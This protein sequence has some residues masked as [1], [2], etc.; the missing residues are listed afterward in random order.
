MIFITRW[1]K[2]SF[3]SIQLR[4]LLIAYPVYI[5]GGSAKSMKRHSSVGKFVQ[6][7][8]NKA[9]IKITMSNKDSDPFKR[10]VYGDSIIFERHLYASGISIYHIK[11]ESSIVVCSGSK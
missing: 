9:E 2:V 4:I 1:N 3:N 6:K 5:L 11:N 8:Q 10:D 7:S